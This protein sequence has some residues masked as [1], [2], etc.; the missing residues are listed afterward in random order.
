MRGRRLPGAREAA[1]SSSC[2]LPR[3]APSVFPV[4]RLPGS[5]GFGTLPVL[6]AVSSVPLRLPSLAR[7]AARPPPRSARPLVLV[8]GHGALGA[9]AQT[10]VRVGSGL[11]Y[12]ISMRRAAMEMP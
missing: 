9:P 10:V 8:R 11:P 7:S 3:L 5:S 4:S 2:G 1:F 12:Q 6:P